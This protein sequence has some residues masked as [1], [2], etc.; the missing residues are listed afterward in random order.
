MFKE[1]FVLVNHRY[2]LM[3]FGRLTALRLT[4]P[5]PSLTKVLADGE[6][7]DKDRKAWQ[8]QATK[9]FQNKRTRSV[10]RNRA[11]SLTSG[12][13]RVRRKDFGGEVQN[14]LDLLAART[15]LGSQ[16]AP[17]PSVHVPTTSSNLT[18]SSG[19]GTTS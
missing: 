18:S 1:M 13:P 4:I 8:E 7:L 16:A 12:H 15:L 10:S 2:G 6:Q 17:A 11:K 3:N 14:K 9:S 5:I 19:V